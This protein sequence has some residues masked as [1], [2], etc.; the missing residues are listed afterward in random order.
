MTA[1]WCTEPGAVDDTRRENTIRSC[2]ICARTRA[3]RV[4]LAISV[5]C[6]PAG[7]K[8][9]PTT[10][11]SAWTLVVPRPR[12]L[13]AGGRARFDADRRHDHAR[14]IPGT[15]APGIAD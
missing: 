5:G 3:C 8:E 11:A 14:A 2:T 1:I 10:S 15:L 6:S 7:V 9:G 12:S 13:Q 4:R